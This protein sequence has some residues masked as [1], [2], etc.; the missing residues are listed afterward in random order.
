MF[1]ILIVDDE[2]IEREGIIFL[3]KKFSFDFDIKE[4]SDGEEALE[5]LKKN[6]V[7]VLLTDVRMPF[8]DGIE[9]SQNAKLIYPDLKI[10]IFSGFGEF[11]YAKRAISLGVYDYIL[12]P[13]S[14]AEFKKT[15]E[16]VIEK[17]EQENK[18]KQ[19]KEWRNFTE[20]EHILLKVISGI[21]IES[22]RERF[23]LDNYA[24]FINK[25]KR[26]I[27]MEVDKDLF[28]NHQEF[29]K[30]IL[31]DFQD[32]ADYLNLNPYQGIF[33]FY[34]FIDETV[35]K[36]TCTKIHNVISEEY[37]V[38]CYFS[39]SNLITS[40]SI[41]SEEYSNMEHI[42]E[43]RFFV[44]DKYIFSKKVEMTLESTDEKFDSTILKNIEH[45]IKVRDF[46]SLK[47]SVD[48][49]IKKFSAQ[50]DFSQIYVKF[51]LTNIYRNICNEMKEANEIDLDGEIDK[52]Y[53]S[54]TIQEI[55]DILNNVIDNMEK[56]FS[57][58]S[59]NHRHEIELV[60]SYIYEN[61]GKDLSLDILAEYVY[62]APSYLSSM[63]KKETS[64]GINVFIKNY[65]MEKAK[66]MLEN[67]NIRIKDIGNIV[68]YSNTSYFCQSFKEFYGLTPE[69]YRQKDEN[70]E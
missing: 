14:Q 9:L 40:P 41:I 36:N 48:L 55:R 58:E 31:D 7:D 21:P 19:A 6:S 24:D 25:Y 67:T 42:M 37:G 43:Q 70:N 30:E 51:I 57:K 56:Q 59:F 26:M 66:D 29:I 22:I 39:I 18:E 49:L 60:K 28:N 4:C 33:F 35:L 34:E 38:D 61:Y 8:M 45:H 46:C 10:I 62:M 52:I 32:K 3:I 44:P 68:G 17:I 50:S 16:S 5:Y 64:V 12:K 54:R 13:I 11:E 63:F 53:S 65:R 27:L 47:S 23:S 20:K 69:K 15:I 2:F 1:K